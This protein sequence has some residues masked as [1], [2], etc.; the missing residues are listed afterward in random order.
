MPDIDLD[1]VATA[2]AER[3]AGTGALEHDRLRDDFVRTCLPF[4]GRLARRYA[5]RGEPLEDIEQVARMGLV[6]AVNRY[7]PERGSF[8]AYAVMTVY[9][10]IKRHFRDK[11]WPVHVARSLQNL[12]LTVRTARAD[13]VAVLKREPSLAEIARHLDVPLADVTE[14]L[15]SSAH[16]S[17]QSL[18]APAGRAQEAEIGDLIGGP[19]A[20]LESVDDRMTLAGLLRHLP[21]REQR[22]IALRFYGNRTQTQIAA[23]LGISQMHVSRLL[24]AAL[25]W[26]REAMISESPP[27]WNDDEPRHHLHIL[28][29]PSTGTVSVIGEVERDTAARFRDGLARAL[30]GTHTSPIVIDLSRAMLLDATGIAVLIDAVRCANLTN[31]KL[32]L[33]HALPPVAHVLAVAGMSHLIRLD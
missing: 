9:G 24:S 3:S 22:L 30:S 11:T 25:N 14:A 2:Y 28:T 26:L 12:G 31:R 4:A 32:T 10:E 29:D 6:K 16:Y 7:Q 17:P 5:G 33:T 18:N 8:T 15:R 1:A 21:E 23:E 20:A 27:P 19:D 13:L